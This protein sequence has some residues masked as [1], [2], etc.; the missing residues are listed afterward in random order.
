MKYPRLRGTDMN[1]PSRYPRAACENRTAHTNGPAWC[2]AH[3]DK[4]SVMEDHLHIHRIDCGVLD[5]SL[6]ISQQ[7]HQPEASELHFELIA[8]RGG[9]AR[10]ARE[11]A[12]LLTIAADKF[13]EIV[14]AS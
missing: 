4:W 10:E 7:V 8:T 1:T 11:A 6:T 13:D 2:N 9:G 14:A 12:R 5:A 3:D